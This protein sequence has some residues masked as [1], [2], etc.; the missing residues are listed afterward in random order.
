MFHYILAFGN[1][2]QARFLGVGACLMINWCS[3]YYSNQR[4][5]PTFSLLTVPFP[6]VK[7]P[8]AASA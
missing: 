5:S 8:L 7:L 2:N 3:R 4:G 6:I 1:L